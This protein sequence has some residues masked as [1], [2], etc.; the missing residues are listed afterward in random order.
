MRTPIIEIARRERKRT[1]D[2]GMTIGVYID[3]NVWDFLFKRRIDLAVALPRDEFC[4]CVTR[5]AEFEI[6]PTPPEKKAFIEATIAKCSI[7]TDT[8]F[9]FNDNSLPSDEQRIGGF[10]VGRWASPEEI[11]FIAS[12]RTALKAK[13]KRP[14]KLHPGE[15][16]ISLAARS[17]HSVVLSLDKKKGPLKDAYEQGGKVVFLTDFDKS[18]MS[19]SDFI[20]AACQVAPA[21]VA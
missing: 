2:G 7:Q 12:Q 3:H 6:P 9:G 10:N 5:E 14:T 19:L 16:D 11:A 17:F 4:L 8:F 21:K 15:A 18:G 1:G 20:K 13:K